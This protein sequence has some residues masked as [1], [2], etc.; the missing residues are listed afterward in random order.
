MKPEIQKQLSILESEPESEQALDALR[1]QLAAEPDGV[2]PDL[3][4][5][6]EEARRAHRE[7]GEFDLVVRLIEVELESTR[8]G[9]ARA[10]LLYEKA[11]VLADELLREDEATAIFHEVLRLRP[12]DSGASEALAHSAL[13]RDN[14]EKIVKKYLEEAK[15]SSDRQLT[16]SLY[17]SVAEILHKYQPG[18]A[19]VETWLR[20]SL[21]VEPRNRK[22]S[23]H[24]ERMLKAAGRH[25]ELAAL[26][27]QRIEAAATREDRVAAYLAAAALHA[28]R[29]ERRDAAVEYYKKVLGIDPGNGK[30]LAALVE[31]YEGEENWPSLIRVYE[32]AL[33]ARARG[34]SELGMV[35]QIAMLY[36]RKLA[37]LDQAEEYFRRLRKVAPHQPVML[38]FYR[39]YY[40]DRPGESQKLLA[41]LAQAHKAEEHPDRRLALGVEMARIAEAGGSVEKAIDVWKAVLRSDPAQGEAAQALKRLYR[42]TEKWNALLELLKDEIEAFGPDRVDDKIERYVDIVAIYRDHLNLDVMVINTYNNILQLQPT[43]VGALEALAAKY[44][45]MGRWNDLIIVLGRKADAAQDPQERVALLKRVAGL[46]LD[47]FANASQA[48]APLEQILAVDP[49]EEQAIQ[50]LKDIYTKRR[51]WRAL[52]E[53]MRKEIALLPETDRPARIGEMAR[54]AQER[55]GDAREAIAAWNQLLERNPVDPDALAALAALYEREKRWPA[56]CE[57][58]DR[59]RQ[60]ADDPRVQLALCEKLGTIFAERLDAPVK[61]AEVWRDA[62]KLQPG[63]PRALRVLRELYAQSGQFEALESLFAASGAWEELVD[64]L[65]QVADRA[66]EPALKLRLFTRIAEICGTELKAPERA[67]KAYERILQLDPANL[68]AAQALVP[69]YRDGEKWARLLATHE[70]LLGHAATPPEQLAVLADIRR[71]CEEKLGSKALAFQWCSRAFEIAPDDLEL[72]GELERLAQ[73]ADAWDKLASLYARRA[74]SVTDEDERV[75]LYR[76]LAQLA[77]TR[78]NRRDDARGYYEEVLKRQPGDPEALSALEQIF[79]QAQSWPELLGVYRRR[80]E[81]EVGEGG[82]PDAAARE[83]QLEVLFRVAY[84]EEERLGDVTAATATYQRIDAL[85][86]E[87]PRTLRALARLHLQREQWPELAAVALRELAA[88]TNEDARVALQLQLGELYETRLGQPD[89]GLAAYRAVLALDPIHRGAVAALERFMAPDAASRFEVAPLLLPFYER[90]E[91]HGRL[92]ETLEIV[93]ERTEGAAER[94]TLLK[95]LATLYSRRLANPE[96]AYRSAA[97]VFALTPEDRDARAELATIAEVLDCHADLAGRL[98][99]AYEK[100]DPKSPLARDL[101]LELAVL[102]D[103]RLGKPADAQVYYSL[104]LDMDPDHA[105]AFEALCRLFR[106]GEH[107]KD[108]R[109]LLE[110]RQER[111]P[112]AV[113]RRELLY[114]ICD[115]D[116]GVLED[117]AHAVRSYETVLTLDPAQARAFRA[118]ERL[119]A[120]A[121]QWRE[122]DDLLTRELSVTAEVPEQVQLKY[123]RADLR[124]ARLDD[125][126]GAVDLLE[127]VVAQAPSHEPARKALERF[128]GRPELRLRVARMLEPLYEQDEQWPR[129]VSVLQVQREE[130]VG[131]EQVRLMARIAQLQEERLGSRQL[132]FL[133]WREALKLDPT[134]DDVRRNFERLGTMLERWPDLCA[135]WEDALAA[136]AGDGAADLPLQAEILSKVAVIAETRLGDVTR[137]TATWKR[138]LDLDPGRLDTARPAAEALCRLYEQGKAYHALID[139]LRRQAEW[140][141]DP[142]ERKAKLFA[143]A[144]IQEE[145]LGDRAAAIATWHEVLELDAATP[146]ALDALERLH[147]EAGSWVDLTAVLRRRVELAQSAPARRDLL[148]RIAGIYEDRLRDDDEAIT[149]HRAVLDEIPE[150]AAS[151]EAISRLLQRQERWADLEEVLERRLVAAWAAPD[152]VQ[153]LSQLGALLEHKLARPEQALERYRDLLGMDPEHD[154]ARQ[155]LERMLADEQLRLKAAEVLEPIYGARA[156]FPRLC[157]LHEL[158][159]EASQD[160]PERVRRLRTVAELCE[161]QLHDPERAFAAYARA[162]RDALGDPELVSLLN[163]LQR[164]TVQRQ[165]WAELVALYRDIGADVLEP[166][167]QQRIY[168]TV[169]QLARTQLRDLDLSRDYFRR[170]LDQVPDHE[171]ALDALEGLYL[172]A[173]DWERLLE[174]LQRRAELSEGDLEVKRAYL[175]R[176]ANLCEEKLDRPTEAIALYEQMMDLIPADREAADALERLYAAGSRATDLAALLERRLG[177]ADTAAEAVALSFRLGEIW[178]RELT[179]ADRAIE[180]YRAALSGEPGHAGAIAALERFLAEP[181]QQFAAA[182][183]LEPVY[184]SRQDWPRLIKIYEIRLGAAEDTAQRLALTRRVA[185]LYEEQLEDLDAAFHWYG[186]VFRED[187]SDR[188]IRD[189]L[190]RLA[191]ILDKW[192][193]LAHVLQSYLDD[194]LQDDA[195]TL[196]VSRVLAGVYDDRLGDVGRARLCYQRILNATPEDV[197]AF[198]ALEASLTRARAWHDLLEVYRE[199]V[200]GTLDVAARKTILFKI[201]RVWEGSLQ[202]KTE[203]ITAYRA[204]LDVDAEDH[205]AIENLDRLF[206]AEERWHDLGELLLRQIDGAGDGAVALRYRL[207]ALY[208]ERLH[209][210]SS[211]IDCYEEVLKRQPTHAETIAA[212][213]RL[214]AEYE[215]QFRIDQILEPVYKQLDAWDRLART[216]ESELEFIDDKPQRIEMLSEIARLQETRGR[217]HAAAFGAAA[218]AWLEDVAQEDRIA[219]LERLARQIGNPAAL[220]DT[221]EKGALATYDYELRARTWAKVAE[222]Q[223]LLLADGVAAAAAWRKVLAIHEDDGPALLAL[224]R[225]LE[226][227]ARHD[228]LCT[229]LERRAEL[230]GDPEE[231]KRLYSRVA[232]IEEQQLQSRD[233]AVTTWRHVLSLDEADLAALDA[234]ERLLRQGEAWRELCGVLQRKLELSVGPAER[235]PLYYQLAEVCEIKLGDPYE[236]I[237]AYKSVLGERA[238]DPAALEALD[239]LFGTERLWTDLV[240]ILDARAAITGAPD[241]REELR[242]RAAR[243]TEKEL[244]D[245]IAA[246]GRYRDVLA[247]AP[248]HRGAREALEA[249]LRGDTYRDPAAEV[250]EPFYRDHQEW[251]ALIEVLELKLAVEGD[252]GRRRQLG[253]EIARLHEEGRR[254]LEAA[255]GAWARVLVDDPADA[256]THGE[257]E[258]LAGARGAFGD[259]ARL[260]E[261]RLAATFDGEL[262]RALC[263]KLA[264]IYEE[265]LGDVDQAVGRYRKTLDYPGDERVPLAALDRLLEGQRAHVDLGEVLEREANAAT[266]PEEQAAYLFRLGLLRERELGDQDGALAAYR[267]VLEREATHRDAR[268]ALERLLEQEAL[269]PRVLDILEPLYEGAGDF[270]ALAR[271]GEVRLGLL[272]GHGDRARLLERIAE[273]WEHKLGGRGRALETYG[274]ALCEEPGTASLADEVERLAREVGRLDEAVKRFEALLDGGG[275]AP[276]V[277]RDLSTRAARLWREQAEFDKAE[278]RYRAVLDVDPENRDALEAIEAICRT[279]GDD[280]ALV[281]ILSRRAELEL[282]P[283]AKKRLL[284]EAARLSEGPLR[285]PAGAVGAWRAVLAEDDGDPDALGALDRLYEAAGQHA[286]LGAI[287]EQEARFADAKEVQARLK[288]RLCKLLAGPLGELE[289]ATDAYRDLLDLTGDDLDV[290]RELEQVQAQRGDW[291]AVQE[292][293]VRALGATTDDAGKVRLYR[294]LA[295]VAEQKRESAEEAIGFLYQVLDVDARDREAMAELERLLAKTEKW[296]DL[297]ELH[298]RRADACTADRDTAGEIAA[299]LAAARVWEEKLSSPDSAVEILERITQR[300]PNNVAALAALARVYERQSQWERCAEVLKRAVTL[301]AGGREAAEIHYRLGRMQ[302]EQMGD[303]AGALGEYE[304]ALGFDPDHAE[305]QEAVAA[306]ARERGDYGRAVQ[307]LERRAQIVTDTAKKLALLRELADMYKDKLAQPGAAV[308]FLEEARTLAPQDAGVLEPL[309]DFYYAAGRLTDA[310]PLYQ[311]LIARLGKGRRTKDQARLFYRLGAVAEQGGDLAMAVKQYDEAYRIDTGHTPTLAALGRV[312]FEQQDWEKARRIYRSMLLQNLDERAGVSKADVYLK[313]GLIH[314]KLGENPKARNMYERGLELDPAHTAL[315]EAL[316]ALK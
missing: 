219:D 154:G 162:V 120:A 50:Q 20:K 262:G 259:L 281:A 105:P 31:V 284:V 255:F 132:A 151:L 136:P 304:Q 111:E 258:R 169:A 294:R 173:G 82:A 232:V 189:Q 315:R 307:I 306:A 150:E 198:N 229:V 205:E 316:A 178:E 296:Y 108:L 225:L 121:A 123:R 299:L 140:A 302:A 295:E 106:Q 199:R 95:R 81:I 12:D 122:L 181:E 170:V 145:R 66:D 69:I 249:L 79:M 93:L 156:D 98:A 116:E 240:E 62:L 127:E 3:A 55:L 287:L 43:H 2:A 163:A 39:A 64:T 288:R 57:M 312:Y 218:R 60:H 77:L 192:I 256:A 73:E 119:Y 248:Q 194:T 54:L 289:R 179:D 9:G 193:D 161:E 138:M 41:V 28:G 30:A 49:A 76:K 204:V 5:G 191:G 147:T 18:N 266:A 38:E 141:D 94:V 87:H 207:G 16:T 112:D 212:L 264:R 183:V 263:L 153:L 283:A 176:A 290:L 92:A 155:G 107:F 1:S 279:R 46:W 285:D 314:A 215:H 19:E 174:I 33:R 158:W 8:D 261:E 201:C 227:Q 63:H 228:E 222:V 135:G 102:N 114:Q 61:A 280:R 130:A 71:L 21:E 37:Q 224:E 190:Q 220:V 134:A 282:D 125:A 89:R 113:A 246:I 236:A 36:W 202:S 75:R 29:L 70:I 4:R 51:Q 291:L 99:A 241:A 25:V 297:I 68:P 313:L 230:T 109:A 187:P 238:G 128:L 139:I 32:N 286:E 239:R 195:A 278:V 131:H 142:G 186:K 305:A 167:L 231:R 23:L 148:H 117:S 67:T 11:R 235:V 17:L 10:T 197:S 184:A 58:L 243:V 276:E 210:L 34:E 14:W 47:K 84:I 277:V 35:I 247:A 267:D 44:E 110:Q 226:R 168:L 90:T 129:L 242:Y 42:K 303:A 7:H 26:Y 78:L 152:K 103:E 300:D 260:Y 209:D 298:T 86:P 217:N 172:E 65:H 257:L 273:L 27:E 160:P 157:K 126:M 53:L 182:E 206:T 104:V 310:A 196:E 269:K 124:A 234:L 59:Q 175:G 72:R 56:L 146:Q 221:L 233:R 100:A 200:E 165:K 88:A 275:L 6:L 96:A 308:R 144:A 211:A 272:T 292:T 40:G 293:L 188:H 133:T 91:D 311:D 185:R 216:Y 251:G 149:A 83:R 213:E 166:A 265:A 270:P 137:A 252:P 177:F 97:R 214:H 159:A 22:A 15:S 74:A 301:C 52:L 115:L 271:L 180:H 24:L 45:A 274:R 309:A 118:L 13:I 164:L 244:D 80:L 253:A 171:G 203:A 101:A 250:L 85:A 245:V 254:D 223:E 237:T 208:Q 268:G 48:V 143:I